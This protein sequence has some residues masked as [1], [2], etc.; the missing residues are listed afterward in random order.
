M[1]RYYLT[2]FKVYFETYYVY[3]FA[4]CI[5]HNNIAMTMFFFNIVQSLSLPLK[6]CSMYGWSC[7][8][9]VTHYIICKLLQVHSDTSMNF[10]MEFCRNMMCGPTIIIHSQIKWFISSQYFLAQS[11]ISYDRN[12][13]HSWHAT[14]FGPFAVWGYKALKFSRLAWK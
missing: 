6:L 11:S 13:T 8:R 1:Y 7:L 9:R 5:L 4:I 2:W 12:M 14:F 3:W 10:C